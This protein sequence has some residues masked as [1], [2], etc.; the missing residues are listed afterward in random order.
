MIIILCTNHEDFKIVTA[1]I[2]LPKENS[3]ILSCLK[4]PYVRVRHIQQPCT[5]ENYCF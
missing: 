3:V 5:V 4:N 2:P 1:N